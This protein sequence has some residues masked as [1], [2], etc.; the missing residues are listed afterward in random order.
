VKSKGCIHTD[1]RNCGCHKN[2]WRLVRTLHSSASFEG[3]T[4][5]E[6]GPSHWK[7]RSDRRLWL[8]RLLCPPC[9][10]STHPRASEKSPTNDGPC[11]HCVGHAIIEASCGTHQTFKNVSSDALMSTFPDAVSAQQQLL[12]SAWCASIF[13]VRLLASKSYT[14][15]LL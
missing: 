9:G 4:G 5:E 12:T 10:R 6:P 11:V 1:S 3:P 15:S 8:T 13:T 2:R 7:S 14:S